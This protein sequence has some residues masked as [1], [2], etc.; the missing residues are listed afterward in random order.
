MFNY[1]KNP[2]LILGF[3]YNIIR[4]YSLDRLAFLS[5][6]SIGIK[7]IGKNHNHNQ[8]AEL[9]L[10]FFAISKFKRIINI[11]NTGKNNIHRVCLPDLPHNLNIK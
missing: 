1:L 8:N 11:A 2:T 10:N 5:N 3:L 7:T 4:Y 9:L 6:A